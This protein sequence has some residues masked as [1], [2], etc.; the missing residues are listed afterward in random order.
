MPSFQPDHPMK[1]LTEFRKFALKGNVI[2]LAVGVMIGGAFGK[3]VESITKDIITPIIGALGGQPDFSAMKL[4]PL[5]VGNLLNAVVA[6]LITAA[7]LFFVFVRPMN[8]LKALL[9]KE[10]AAA[11]PPAPA[12]D[13]V[14]LT[15]IRD[16]LKK[17]QG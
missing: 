8:R 13:V 5:L 15:E 6:F 14:L 1:I 11:P 2:D 7:V 3:I 16:L 17:Q 12:P 4:G 10:E 9:D